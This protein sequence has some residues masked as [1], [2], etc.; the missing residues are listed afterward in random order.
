MSLDTKEAVLSYI[1]SNA[2]EINFYEEIPKEFQSDPEVLGLA[3]H[4]GMIEPTDKIRDNRD[5]WVYIVKNNKRYMSSSLLKEVSSRLKDDEDFVEIVLKKEIRN[6]QYASERVKN[7]SKWAWKATEEGLYQYVPEPANRDPKMILRAFE[8]HSQTFYHLPEDLRDNRE[9]IDLAMKHSLGDS[10]VFDAFPDTYKDDDDIAFQMVQ[11]SG[12]CFRYVSNR[13]K[14]NR[15]LAL[16]SLKKDAR[17]LSEMP[18]EFRKDPEIV[19]AAF[20]GGSSFSLGYSI[21]DVAAELLEQREFAE[22]GSETGQ[23]LEFFPVWQDD[24]ELVKKF[25]AKDLRNYKQ[26]SERLRAEREVVLA[27]VTHKH[28]WIDLNNVPKEFHNDPEV[29]ELSLAGTASN[30]KYIGTELLSDKEFLKKMISEVPAILSFLPKEIGA[31]LHSATIETEEYRNQI[32]QISTV[33]D[34]NSYVSDLQRMIDEVK[35]KR[36]G[37]TELSIRSMP[38]ITYE[39]DGPVGSYLSHRML[40]NIVLCGDFAFLVGQNSGHETYSNHTTKD[41]YICCGYSEDCLESNS[42]FKNHHVYLLSPSSESLTFDEV[43]TKSPKLY[44]GRKSETLPSGI[45][46]FERTHDYSTI[47]TMLTQNKTKDTKRLVKTGEK[48]I[49]VKSIE[50]PKAVDGAARV[51]VTDKGWRWLIPNAEGPRAALQ[52]LK[53]STHDD[54]WNWFASKLS[55]FDAT[56]KKILIEHFQNTHLHEKVKSACH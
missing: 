19:R 47:M 2:R 17:N 51:F 44:E 48:N 22:L 34:T 6:Y 14:A 35:I 45:H 55:T 53:D 16:L 21:R 36:G 52:K 24:V 30:A 25:I 41:S 38:I 42:N 12:F 28:S 43:R 33:P 26:A 23:W 20:V 39:S 49:Q 3:I 27:Y 11:K 37:Q 1:Q 4:H 50:E 18:I 29:V 9:Y 46:I 8:T 32:I 7:I 31:S 10:V 40:Y 13:L 56:A 54:D 15:E 5:I